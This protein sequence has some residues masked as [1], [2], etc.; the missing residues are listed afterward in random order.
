MQVL[1]LLPGG[2]EDQLQALPAMAAL[3]EQQSA[4]LHVVCPAR[5]A[6]IWTLLPAVE[7]CIPF[8]FDQRWSLADW[9]NLLG[10]VREP[11][12]QASL[13][14]S[15][16][17][18][19]DLLLSL[20]HIPMRVASGGFSATERV[21]QQTPGWRGQAL[22]AWLQPLG[23]HCDADAYRL[24]LPQSALTEARASLPQG[25]GPALLLAPG[26]V[27]GG[28]SPEDWREL[29]EAMGQAVPSVRL[30]WLAGEVEEPAGVQR[31]QVATVL[32]EAA[33]VASVDVV[34]TDEPR[35]AQLA[36]LTGTAL[37]AAGMEAPHRLPQRDVIKP[38][39]PLSQLRPK[40]VLQALAT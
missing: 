11:D 40:E 4:Q 17:W 32:A 36:V 35:L 3:A 5:A 10:N 1:A 19:I 33:A 29:V 38:L 23:M 39:P 15:T 24:P 8:A 20:T 28:W 25:N 37:V 22:A 34:L 21:E 26:A 30:L 13:N 16:D 2:E 7:H 12:F 6:N 9:T 31:C 14:L 27:V 18:S